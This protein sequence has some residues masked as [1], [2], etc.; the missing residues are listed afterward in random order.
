MADSQRKM[1][2][3]YKGRESNFDPNFK[4]PRAAK[5]QP[6]G[7]VQNPP[8][9]EE[10][11][12]PSEK[13]SPGRKNQNNPHPPSIPKPTHADRPITQVTR[14]EPIWKEAIFAPEQSSREVNTRVTHTPSLSSIIEVSKD[15]ISHVYAVEPHMEKTLLREAFH[16]YVGGLAWLRMLAIKEKEVQDRTQT[17]KYLY[18]T[19]K[20]TS[21]NIPEPIYLYLKA[22]GKIECKTGQHLTPTFPPM[23]EIVIN[24]NGGY[25]GRINENTHTLYEEIPNLGVL[26]EALR[27]AIS[28]ANPGRYD[29]VLRLDDRNIPNSNLLGYEPLTYRRDE[30]KN[31]ILMQGVTN[32]LLPSSFGNTGFNFGLMVAL[33]N[34]I[35]TIKSFKIINTPI[36]NLGEQGS[37]A[38]QIITY[39]TE[40]SLPTRNVIGDN[41]NTSL[42]SESSSSYGLAIIA[43]FHRMKENQE[44]GDPLNTRA[45]S[46]ICINFQDHDDQRLI[47]WIA[48]RNERRTLPV[49]FTADVFRSITTNAAQ[50]RDSV[51][52]RLQSN[53]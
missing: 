10:M 43:G 34:T 19:T 39:P 21:F 49:Q 52:Q 46:W 9:K 47:D 24:G 25:F 20:D 31:A 45:K 4:D 41:Y 37:Q 23:P 22:I 3:R 32:L 5:H 18:S 29:S 2:P 11:T 7:T 44:N 12:K 35:G 13:K 26:G 53:K 6:S 51:V 14:D 27:Q 28:G 38:M 15:T 36:P 8:A 16:Y 50:Y 42:S 40:L 1:N 33:S 30:A 17:E 48:N